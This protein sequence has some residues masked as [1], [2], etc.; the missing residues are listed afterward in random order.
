[1]GW[2]RNPNGFEETYDDDY[3]DDYSE[4]EDLELGGWAIVDMG[5]DLIFDGFESEV[6]AR[7][8]IEANQDM[9]E[10]DPEHYDV[11]WVEED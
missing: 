9:L 4:D 2:K 8:W 10:G 11:V 3:D 5:G 7:E 6:A 1:M